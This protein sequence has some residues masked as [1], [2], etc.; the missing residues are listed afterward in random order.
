MKFEYRT[1]LEN[2]RGGKIFLPITTTSLVIV[3]T[4]VWMATDRW[5]STTAW[6]S[7]RRAPVEWQWIFVRM[8]L[9]LG[10]GKSDIRKQVFQWNPWLITMSVPHIS[11]M[12]RTELFAPHFCNQFTC[13]WQKK[14]Y[15]WKL[16]RHSPGDLSVFVLEKNML[17]VG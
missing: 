13:T 8:F 11:L 5:V 1:W 17:R 14:T 15:K 4:D 6:R 3:L 10:E 2:Y 7:A 16:A 9:L 12:K